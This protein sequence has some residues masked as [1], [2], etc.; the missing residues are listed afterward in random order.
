[1]S[2]LEPRRASEHRNR[3]TSQQGKAGRCA[4]EGMGNVLVCFFKMHSHKKKKRETISKNIA[5]HDR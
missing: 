1:M 2:E 3:E 5:A 4:Q